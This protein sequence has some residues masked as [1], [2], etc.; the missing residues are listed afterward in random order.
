MKEKLWLTLIT[1]LA[2]CIDKE[3]YKAIDYLREQVRVLVEQQEKQNRRILLTNSQRMRV[4]A[5]AKRLSRKMLDQCTELFTPGTIMRWYRELISEKYDGSQ[6]RTY[7]GRPP[8]TQEI[9]NLVIRFKEENP[10]WGY[11]KIRDQVVYLG[12]AICKSSVKNILIE[13]S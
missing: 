1:C 9:V 2:Y 6:N 5:K 3:L 12:Y 7:A 4:A 8:I 10:R 11:Q 13:N